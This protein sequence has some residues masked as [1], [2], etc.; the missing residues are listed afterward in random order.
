MCGYN[1]T[2]SFDTLMDIT[3]QNKYPSDVVRLCEYFENQKMKLPEYCFLEL[4]IEKPRKRNE[5]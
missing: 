3:K 1:L 5:F 2:C 4:H